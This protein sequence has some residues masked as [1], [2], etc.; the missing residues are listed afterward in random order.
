MPKKKDAGGAG[1]T[2]P[3]QPPLD[4]SGGSRRDDC[5]LKAVQSQH[6]AVKDIAKTQAWESVLTPNLRLILATLVLIV[7]I[8][9]GVQMPWALAA[10]GILGRR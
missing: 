6:E 3:I 1:P 9:C 5:W 10:A 8:V 2:T 7:A 4:P